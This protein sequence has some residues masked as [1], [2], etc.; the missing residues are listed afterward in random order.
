MLNYLY[1]AKFD[2][3][4]PKHPDLAKLNVVNPKHV[5]LKKKKMSFIL[6]MTI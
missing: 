3:V 1:I 4:Y 2:V 5:E 6:K